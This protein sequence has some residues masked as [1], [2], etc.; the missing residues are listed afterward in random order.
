[1]DVDGGQFPQAPATAPGGDSSLCAAPDRLP[2]SVAGCSTSCV[3]QPAAQANA[4]GTNL[5]AMG[6]AAAASTAVGEGAE[7]DIPADIDLNDLNWDT[8]LAA[9]GMQQ[10]DG[11]VLR[12]VVVD[13]ANTTGTS[14]HSS[15]GCCAALMIG[16]SPHP[17][18]ITVDAAPEAM[19]AAA[20]HQ[21][22]LMMQ[23]GGPRGAHPEQHKN[24]EQ[25]LPRIVTAQRCRAHP[26]LLSS[27]RVQAPNDPD[28][29][30]TPHRPRQLHTSGSTSGP[31]VSA[32]PVNLPPLQRCSA[33]TLPKATDA[34][35]ARGGDATAGAIGAG[36]GSP[37]PL[38]PAPTVT[39]SVEAPAAA[40]SELQVC[41]GAMGGVSEDGDSLLSS[42]GS[43]TTSAGTA[44]CPAAAA[45]AAACTTAAGADG[46]GP[47]T[48]PKRARTGVAEPERKQLPP[49]QAGAAAQPPALPQPAAAA[50]GAA[51]APRLLSMQPSAPP[52]PGIVGAAVAPITQPQ[53]SGCL[54]GWP[55]FTTTC[56]SSHLTPSSSAA[57]S[58]LDGAAAPAGAAFS[59]SA[60]HQLPHADQHGQH[61]QHG[62]QPHGAVL[63]QP[64]ISLPCLPAAHSQPP[65]ELPLTRSSPLQPGPSLPQNAPGA[66]TPADSLQQQPQR[67]Q[68]APSQ[69]MQQTR[70]VPADPLPPPLTARQLAKAAAA[71]A[72]AATLGLPPPDLVALGLLP[73]GHRFAFP[74]AAS[75][76][77]AASQPQITATTSNITMSNTGSGRDTSGLRNTVAQL[78]ATANRAHS[79]SL[80]LGACGSVFGAPDAAAFAAAAG[81]SPP[82]HSSP[83]LGVSTDLPPPLPLPRALPL[84]V[85]PLSMHRQAAPSG[86]SPQQLPMRRYR[87]T[88]L[89][90]V[91][92]G[93]PAAAHH[94]YQRHASATAST[95]AAVAAGAGPTSATAGA[96][97][98][99]EAPVRRSGQPASGSSAGRAGNAASGDEVVLIGNDNDVGDDADD[100]FWELPQSD[101]YDGAGLGA[102]PGSV[103]AGC[104][105]GRSRA[106]CPALPSGR[107]GGSGAVITTG[108]PTRQQDSG[109]FGFAN[110][111]AWASRRRS[112]GA[113]AGAGHRTGGDEDGG[114]ELDE[115][116]QSL[117]SSD[118]DFEDPSL[119]DGF[120]AAEEG[121]PT[122]RNLMPSLAPGE[123]MGPG[124]GAGASITCADTDTH[125]AE[126]TPGRACTLQQG[127][128]SSNGASAI[129]QQRE[130][131]HLSGGGGFAQTGGDGDMQLLHA[132]LN[133]RSSCG[134]GEGGMPRRTWSLPDGIQVA[135]EMDICNADEEA[136]LAAGPTTA[137]SRAVVSSGKAGSVAAALRASRGGARA[138]GGGAALQAFHSLQPEAMPAGLAAVSMSPLG[139]PASLQ[140]PGALQLSTGGGAHSTATAGAGNAAAAAAPT[141]AAHSYSSL[142]HTQQFQQQRHQQP[143][144]HHGSMEPRRSS[145]TLLHVGPQPCQR[146]HTALHALPPQHNHGASS[147]GQQSA[148]AP[149]GTGAASGYP[150]PQQLFPHVHAHLQPQAQAPQ[151]S[152]PC[153][154]CYR[155]TAAAAA[156]RAVA[157]AAAAAAAVSGEAAPHQAPQHYQLPSAVAAC[158]SSS[159]QHQAYAH[160]YSP[161]AP[162]HSYPHLPHYRAPSPPQAY[163]HH[164]L[165]GAQKAPCTLPCC[166]PPCSASPSAA[167]WGI[168]AGHQHPAS[169]PYA[170]A[171]QPSGYSAHA[172]GAPAYPPAAGPRMSSPPTQH[173][174]H[175]PFYAGVVTGAGAPSGSVYEAGAAGAHSRPPGAGAG[176]GAGAGVGAAGGPS[177]GGMAGMPALDVA[178]HSS[179]ATAYMTAAYLHHRHAGQHPMTMHG[180]NYAPAPSYP[181]Y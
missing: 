61:S 68:P 157:A 34:G 150:Q 181:S 11:G 136:A 163:P 89:T 101:M 32:T 167:S 1:M 99:G 23:Q 39:S 8:F 81:T 145:A 176:A 156:A 25:S 56:A 79:G 2:D 38:N 154:D 148:A 58:S 49:A 45:A 93:G 142:P 84:P 88:S 134:G 67:L 113:A 107:H 129:Q 51:G 33:S 173:Q 126:A 168:P 87:S 117:K 15:A 179:A 121:K 110:S 160:G 166:Y 83:T 18:T 146:Q 172:L 132:L 116:L 22:M 60:F 41:G 31:A 74:G 128:H 29:E 102:M 90:A 92:A 135:S 70:Q 115:L 95:A 10:A 35:V 59:G 170:R 50:A 138:S 91:A 152:C 71:V 133:V 147:F 19:A 57:R 77:P 24:Q 53:G 43:R 111:G 46:Q 100:K 120:E 119:Q 118:F 55:S 165:H 94:P 65:P 153:A 106:S 4:S 180:A 48:S 64:Q 169:Y 125:M 96:L 97:A 62:Q 6:I 131:S 104:S 26:A 28:E 98:A 141:P 109:V 37:Q 3:V 178:A 20:A 114:E 47:G 122:G 80:Q 123:A 14:P 162:Y 78:Q 159:H 27:A 44:L 158:A 164:Q 149:L 144:L 161:Y 69:S 72:A 175:A 86:G 75:G 103:A 112:Q 30:Q 108:V 36:E 174:G 82:R 73:P 105:N 21:G 143:A 171:H 13:L 54:A 16:G 155:A 76:V 40:A 12:D 140:H 85:P 124:A 5:S 130:P 137:T 7:L 177:A 42:K 139:T 66:L 52:P 63:S 17:A 151:S 127:R 9:E